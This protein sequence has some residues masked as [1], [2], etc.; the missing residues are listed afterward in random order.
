MARINDLQKVPEGHLGI[1]VLGEG[2][3]AALIAELQSAALEA[4][5][6]PSVVVRVETEADELAVGM[7]RLAE[8]GYRGVNVGHPFKP[9]AARLAAHFYVVKH[10]LGTANALMLDSGVFAQNTEVTSFM[11]TLE[12]LTPS[13]AL[14]LGAGHSARSVVMALLD[15]GWKVRIWSRS[16]LKARPL[17]TLL[18]RHGPIELLPSPDPVGAGLIVNATPLG[19]RPGEMP[20]LNWSHVQRGAVIYDLVVRRVSTELLRA[21][22]LRGLKTVDGRELMIEQAAQALEW[23]TGKPVPRGPMRVQAWKRD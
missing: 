17:I 22:T 9:A 3:D 13:A 11:K 16:A 20:P 5:S 23:W 19:M 14:V 15:S 21:A 1:A 10:S 2:A 12:G 8:L 7:K 6:V 4:M 18:Q